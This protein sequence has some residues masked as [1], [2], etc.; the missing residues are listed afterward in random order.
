LAPSGLPRVTDI[1]V[2]AQIGGSALAVAMFTVLI[3]GV[4]PAISMSRVDVNA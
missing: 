3:F 4:L 2:D 1:L